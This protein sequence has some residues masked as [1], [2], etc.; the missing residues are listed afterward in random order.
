MELRGLPSYIG[1]LPFLRRFG[2]SGTS[3]GTLRGFF[4]RFFHAPAHGVC[5]AFSSPFLSSVLFSGGGRGTPPY[6]GLSLRAAGHRAKRWPRPLFFFTS[7]LQFFFLFL[8][9][10]H[11]RHIRGF[12]C[13]TPGFLRFFG[14]FL[15]GCRGLRH[16]V[17]L[18]CFQRF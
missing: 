10:L 8:D 3:L 1:I 15:L 16:A 9:F 11:F 5:R 12:A 18:A 14:F 2:L 6:A 13:D 17:V 4:S 7:F